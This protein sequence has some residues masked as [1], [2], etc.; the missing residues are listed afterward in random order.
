MLI[1]SVTSLWTL[2][3][4]RPSVGWLVLCTLMSVCW[5]VGRSVCHYFLQ[6]LTTFLSLH[7]GLSFLV[8]YFLMYDPVSP[9]RFFFISYSISIS[10]SVRLSVP[11]K[12]NYIIS[13]LHFLY[14]TF[15]GYNAFHT[16]PS[17]ASLSVCLSQKKGI[18]SFD[19]ELSFFM[20]VSALEWNKFYIG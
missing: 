5:L 12:A 8:C 6:N 9:G 17:K 14:V 19:K 1:G 7:L 2:N 13:D 15:L 4:V 20:L 3:P 10:H 18:S 16:E 11:R